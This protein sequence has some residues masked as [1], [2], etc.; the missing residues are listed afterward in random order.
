MVDQCAEA[1]VDPEFVHAVFAYFQEVDHN[2]EVVDA[3]AVGGDEVGELEVG[4]D[5][6]DGDGG[7]VGADD[8]EGVGAVVEPV[9][10]EAD[11][12]V[13]GF[14]GYLPAVGRALVEQGVEVAGALVLRDKPAEGEPFG[15][16]L[17]VE[18]GFGVVDRQVVGRPDEG[19]LGG[20]EDPE[21][22]VA[23]D[24]VAAMVAVDGNE[25]E[26]EN[27]GGVE[28]GRQEAVGAREGVALPVGGPEGPLA[29]DGG[30]GVEQAQL[31]G[32]A[33]EE[34]GVV[35]HPGRTVEADD[36]GQA[37]RAVARTQYDMHHAVAVVDGEVGAVEFGG[38]A[39]VEAL[40]D[41]SAAGA[42]DDGVGKVVGGMDGEDERGDGV[43][44]V[45][46]GQGVGER[47][48]GREGVAVPGVGHL[49]VAAVDMEGVGVVAVDV[50]CV[51]H[52]AVASGGVDGV[53]HGV[54]QAEQGRGRGV[55]GVGHGGRRRERRGVGGKGVLHQGVVDGTG[56]VA[57]HGEVH[58]DERVGPVDGGNDGLVGDDGGDGVGLVGAEEDAVP[59][60]GQ[61][62]LAEAVGEG[63]GVVA[64]DDEVEGHGAVAVLMVQEGMDEARGVVGKGDAVPSVGQ[65]VLDDVV[66]DDGVGRVAEGEVEGDGAVAAQGV[67]GDVDGVGVGGEGGAVPCEAVA[68]AGGGV[69]GGGGVDGEV[70]DVDAVADAGII[71]VH[72]GVLAGGVV[73]VAEEG[74]LLVVADD[75]VEGVEVQGC[76]GIADGEPEVEAAVA[77]VG[78]G[79]VAVELG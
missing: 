70:E 32:T 74:V 39:V 43:G 57:E 37:H 71:E 24:G 61:E 68:G 27:A 42:D 18:A 21:G 7:G 77:A 19:G 2:P 11:G 64:V 23:A 13:A 8:G 50:E 58:G 3:V 40:V 17:V 36:G 52:G 20:G 28:A 34:G 76:R 41:E 67:G 4:V 38:A 53:P 31:G 15:R 26:G 56:A 59:G 63:G 1:V 33:V 62:A 16:G 29:G 49:V 66:C 51:D 72:L 48:V 75:G 47:G 10:D 44:A 79:E 35:G 5:D 30:C 22:G 55:D 6:G 46:G 54:G 14:D 45:D 60:V 25:L 12:V 65:G 73:G 69:A 9:G 78:G